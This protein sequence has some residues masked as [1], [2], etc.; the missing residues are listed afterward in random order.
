MAT[1]DLYKLAK[2][3]HS[4]IQTHGVV[5]RATLNSQFKAT[6]DQRSTLALNTVLKSLIHYGH[7]VRH[8]DQ[9][10]AS[11]YFWAPGTESPYTAD[12]AAVI[13]PPDEDF[14]AKPEPASSRVL[15][16]PA[17]E[18]GPVTATV[19]QPSLAPVTPKP[20][21][22]SSVQDT[23]VDLT[24]TMQEDLVQ[25]K[26]NLSGA[27]TDAVLK[28]LSQALPFFTQNFVLVNFPTLNQRVFNMRASLL[29]LRGQLHHSVEH[30]VV[31]WSPTKAVPEGYTLKTVALKE[32]STK[33]VKP[34]RHLFKPLPPA[35]TEQKSPTAF[36][37][38]L[39]DKHAQLQPKLEDDALFI[40][41][42]GFVLSIDGKRVPASTVLSIQ[43]LKTVL[44]LN[45]TAA[46][47]SLEESLLKGK[48]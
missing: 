11:V 31:Y 30:P 10:S 44:Q 24:S 1:I 7:L 4:F 8:A 34:K 17:R 15:P 37:Q 42:V 19:P 5:T 45:P 39:E 16:T 47:Q 33:S 18:P 20:E 36:E 9:D 27:T 14:L 13:N 26:A 3:L 28:A 21:K 32:P 38:A 6:S 41:G 23:K 43:I 2:T 35:S 25:L 40:T 29:V 48:P 22:L 12:T 46:L